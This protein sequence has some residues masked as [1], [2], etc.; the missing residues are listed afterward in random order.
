MNVAELAQVAYTADQIRLDDDA[1]G[2]AENGAALTAGVIRNYAKI[3]Y[4]AAK[5]EKADPDPLLEVR[6]CY[7]CCGVRTCDI[8]AHQ[9]RFDR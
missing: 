2:A 6:P 9:Q 5:A 4:R 3:A 7:I 1:R 8:P